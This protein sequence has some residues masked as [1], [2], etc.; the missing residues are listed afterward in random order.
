MS[1]APVAGGNCIHDFSE[2]QPKIYFHVTLHIVFSEFVQRD[3]KVSLRLKF[4]EIVDTSCV[5]V[6]KDVLDSVLWSAQKEQR[7]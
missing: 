7:I 5:N 6:T 3:I 2:F 1:S 4:T